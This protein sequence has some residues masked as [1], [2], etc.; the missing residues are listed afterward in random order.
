M[1][2]PDTV[3]ETGST[4]IVEPKSKNGLKNKVDIVNKQKAFLNQ[5]G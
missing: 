3:K 1:T 2:Q 4:E 5:G